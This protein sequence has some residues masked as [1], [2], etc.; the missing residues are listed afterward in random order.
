MVVT[1]RVERRKKSGHRILIEVFFAGAGTALH[2][3]S[4]FASCVFLDFT[5]HV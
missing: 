2:L 1:D 4:P 5:H 3:T